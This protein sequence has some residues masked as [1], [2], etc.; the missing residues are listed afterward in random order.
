M[1][2]GLQVINATHTDRWVS[3]FQRTI[4]NGRVVG[5]T[6][7]KIKVRPGNAAVATCWDWSDGTRYWLLRPG[8]Y[9]YGNGTVND[10][11]SR[12]SGEASSP[13]LNLRN[14]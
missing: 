8:G 14:P 13:L 11:S 6:G 1:R 2:S 5:T 7:C 3:F 9:A 12:R 10:L 4:I